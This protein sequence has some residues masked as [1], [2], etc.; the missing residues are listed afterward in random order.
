MNAFEQGFM[1][2][3]AALKN[4]LPSKWNSDKLTNLIT[5]GS[6]SKVRKALNDRKFPA[7]GIVDVSQWANPKVRALAASHKN[8]PIVTL[9]RMVKDKDS[10]VASAAKKNLM[11]KQA[12]MVWAPQEE[13][14]SNYLKIP[15]M[16]AGAGALAYGGKRMI[17]DGITFEEGFKSISKKLS[18]GTI[19]AG[20]MIRDLGNRIRAPRNDD[21][22]EIIADTERVLSK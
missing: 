16:L 2:K 6:D 20:E 1:D 22:Y 8:A 10:N 17:N 9:R 7:E 19:Y 11:R 14:M 3:L 15:L 13:G 12:A 18:D 4:A 5:E 21:F